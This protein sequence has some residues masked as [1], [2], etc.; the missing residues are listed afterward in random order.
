MAKKSAIMRNTKREGLT[1][2]FASRRGALKAM[3]RD[4]ALPAEERFDAAMKLSALPRNAS[5]V[6]VHNRCLL[7]GRSKGNYRKFKL[8]RIAFRELASRGLV[9]GVVKASW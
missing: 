4:R 3:Q 9:P 6:R 1:K 8:S 7:T 2:K 5:P